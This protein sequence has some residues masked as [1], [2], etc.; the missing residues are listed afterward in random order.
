MTG[1]ALLR[2]FRGER[3]LGIMNIPLPLNIITYEVPRKS[4]GKTLL[5]LLRDSRHDAAEP[6]GIS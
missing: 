2:D 5:M 1:M 4:D 3:P 6:A